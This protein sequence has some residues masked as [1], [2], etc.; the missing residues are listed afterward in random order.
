M[1][2]TMNVLC[3]RVHHLDRDPDRDP[4]RDLDRNPHNFVGCKWSIREEILLCRD[5]L[6]T[7][8]MILS[9]RGHDS[10]S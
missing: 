2:V 6:I 10:V 4:D 5:L 9:D 1:F 8:Y 7:F 3:K